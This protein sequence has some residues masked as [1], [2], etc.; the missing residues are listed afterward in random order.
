MKKLKYVASLILCAALAASCLKTPALALEKR[1]NNNWLYWSQGA[2]G[3]GGNMNSYGCRI[4]ADAKLLKESGMV[5]ATF[6]PD[7]Y[8]QWANQN[9]YYGDRRSLSAYVGEQATGSPLSQGRGPA[10]YAKANGKTLY[11]CGQVDF[12]AASNRTARV[13]QVMGWLRDG[14]YVILGCGA[15]H[16]YVAR[17]MS[18]RQGTPYIADSG[19]GYINGPITAYKDYTAAN[20]SYVRLYST[21]SSKI[22]TSVS[23]VT[24][25]ADTITQ[26]SAILRGSVSSTGAKMTQCG[27]LIGTSTENMTRLGYDSINTYSTTCFYSTS[28]YGQTLTP[29]TTYYYQVY[30]VADGKEYKGNIRSFTTSLCTNHVKGKYLWYAAEHPHFNFYACS[31]CGG[32]FTDGS[33]SKS[34][35]CKTCNPD[36]QTCTTHVKGKYLWYAAEHPH[37]DH[38]ACAICGQTYRSTITNNMPSCKICNP[39][40]QTCTTHVK[41]KYLWYE[42]EHPHYNYYTC[43]VC[44][45]RFTDYTTSI[46]PSCTICRP[47]NAYGVNLYN[48][49]VSNITATTARLDASCSYTGSCPTSAGIFVGTSPNNLQVIDSDTGLDRLKNPFNLWYNLKG[50]SAG[51]TYYYRFYAVV[52]GKVTYSEIKSFTTSAAK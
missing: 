20:F 42:D 48:L 1:Y 24:T 9:G 29:G 15:H 14:Y 41:G 18:L 3:I 8:A 39:D 4:V 22:I 17:E 40:P 47:V 36:P 12:T 52:D 32:T 21:S 10:G 37:Y 49:K 43:S 6:D 7:I 30:A 25:G 11:Y 35:T 44:G 50:F 2:S 46:M 34:S 26:T 38:Y 27:M 5:P 33:T 31:V 19:H 45:E 23:A 13:N 28:K 16:A 51:T